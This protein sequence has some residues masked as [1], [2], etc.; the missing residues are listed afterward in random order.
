MVTLKKTDGGC[1][2]EGGKEGGKEADTKCAD[3][4]IE[5]VIGNVSSTQT[6]WIRGPVPLCFCAYASSA[7]ESP[8]IL[9]SEMQIPRNISI[10]LFAG[11]PEPFATS[12]EPSFVYTITVDCFVSVIV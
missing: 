2:R 4:I 12:H 11:V 10:A 9:A 6:R 5:A 1:G 7:K 3:R 8:L